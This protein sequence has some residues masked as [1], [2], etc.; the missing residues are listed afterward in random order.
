MLMTVP[1]FVSPY[2]FHPLYSRILNGFS[3]P[4]HPSLPSR[5]QV[6][7]KYVRQLH[8]TPKGGHRSKQQQLQQLPG[9]GSPPDKQQLTMPSLVTSQS[10]LYHGKV[11]VGTSGIGVSS[12]GGA[13]TT[14]HTLKEL[15][16]VAKGN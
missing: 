11:I 16:A 15:K 13:G 2:V 12:A 3:H 8:H 4:S 1:C 14:S 6:E 7:D 5:T 9:G 10:A